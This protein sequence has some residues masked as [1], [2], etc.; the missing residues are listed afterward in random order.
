M[1]EEP[2]LME[3]NV[4]FSKLKS[5]ASRA[6]IASV[7]VGATVLGFQLARGQTSPPQPPQIPPG[8]P[9]PGRPQTPN[10]NAMPAVPSGQGMPFGST[11]GG[12]PPAPPVPTPIASRSMP[13]ASP[14]AKPFVPSQ[15]ETILPA[16]ERPAVPKV[17]LRTS[18]GDVTITLN[19]ADAPNTTQN[20][21]DL[22]RGS[23]EYVDVQTSR[24]VKKPFYNGLFFHRVVS[25]FLIQTGC[26]FGNGRGGPGYTINDEIVPTM[27]F[28]K[29]GL[30]AM[31]PQR[32]GMAVNQNTNGSQFFITLREMP[33]WDGK[34]TIFGEVTSGLKV[35]E[36][37]GKVKIGPTDRPIRRV[38]LNSAEVVDEKP[39]QIMAPPETP[40]SEPAV[41]EPPIEGVPVPQAPTYG[42]PAP[43]SPPSPPSP[44]KPSGEQAPVGQPVQMS[45]PAQN[46]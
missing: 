1:K 13:Q 31:A 9:V 36:R 7:F 32:S 35:V 16:F 5:L 33:E 30:V 4:A 45:A 40:E 3:A 43:P 39:K 41:E 46:P 26:P 23:K 44:P 6:S 38:Y 42:V 8:M 28:N 19:V 17:I 12:P 18:M 20:F 11:N 37:I 22:V 25:N 2:V 34:F 21:L 15:V 24:K 14:T 27:K 10:T 29:P